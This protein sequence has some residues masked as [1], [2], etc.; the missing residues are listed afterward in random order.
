[1]RYWLLFVLLFSTIG[2]G[3]VSKEI[4]EEFKSKNYFKAKELYEKSKSSLSKTDR[5]LIEAVLDNAFNRLRESDKRITKLLQQKVPD[6]VALQLLRVRFDNAVKLY[7]Y[8]TAAES[9]ETILGRFATQLTETEREDFRNSLKIWNAL[10]EEPAQTVRIPGSVQQKMKTDKAGLKN[11]TLFTGTDSIDFIFD[12]G[13]NIST[14]TRSTANKLNMK[15]IPAN[16]KV[17]TIT[18]QSVQADLGVCPRLQF[19][20]IEIRNAVFL[21]FEDQ[22]LHI[23]PIDYQI[24]GIIGFPII[25]ALREIQITKDGYFIV[26]RA[27]RHKPAISNLALDGLTPLIY[28]DGMHFTFDSGADHTMLYQAFYER[29]KAAIEQMYKEDSVAFGG[30]GGHKKFAGYTI[31]HTFN[32]QGKPVVLEKITLLKEKIKDEETVYGN[33]GQDLIR[34]FGKMTLN[35]GQMFIR[36]E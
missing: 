14:I 32:L 12:T 13:A 21:I 24:H 10:R 6:S 5:L 17:G 36:F 1:M 33:I 18:G 27:A 20:D 25:N 15:I 28:L 34:Q 23:A 11:L 26:P 29:N 16:I 31:S 30:A 3:Q 9:I 19:G 2:Y 35:F 8:K 7:N 22:A 4:F